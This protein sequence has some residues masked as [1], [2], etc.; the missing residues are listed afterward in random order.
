MDARAIRKSAIAGSWYPGTPEALAR[1][2]DR[3]LGQVPAQTVLGD[4]V[5]LVAPH[6]GYMYSGP[7]AAYAYRL[8]EGLTFDVVAVISPSHRAYYRDNA[9]TELGQYWTPLG[10]VPVDEDLV[11]E[12]ARHAPVTRVPQDAEHAL[13]IQLPF[14]QRTLTEGWSLLPIMMGDHGLPACRS[15]AQGLATV[16]QGRRALLVASTDLSHFHN[17]ATAH[18]LDQVVVDQVNA[19][20]PVG[21]ADALAANRCEACGGGPTV[22]VMLAAQSLGATHAQVLRYAT[23]A[24]VSG[25]RSSV[26]GYLA[27]AI[28]RTPTRP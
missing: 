1:D 21:L 27:A 7:V 6:A 20:D 25:D 2:V 4:L 17:E 26:V 16:L 19:F 12:L 24:D 5:A 3:C 22:A 23:S 8:L 18:R 14:L 13:E 10:T 15:L 9:I 11:A 28:T